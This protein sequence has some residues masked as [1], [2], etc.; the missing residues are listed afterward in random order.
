[1]TQAVSSAVGVE[2]CLASPVGAND[3]YRRSAAAICSLC[4]Q[5]FLIASHCCCCH[6]LR[7]LIITKPHHEIRVG[8][9]AWLSL[10]VLYPDEVCMFPAAERRNMCRSI[11]YCKAL[12]NHHQL[13]KKNS[14]PSGGYLAPTAPPNPTPT[15]P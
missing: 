7:S 14:A 4:C 13:S 11:L 5:I 3:Q 15:L 6:H 9:Y 1:M 12:L 2:T 10:P 8:L